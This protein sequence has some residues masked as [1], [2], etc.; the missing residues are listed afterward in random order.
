MSNT[1]KD[2]E[3]HVEDAGGKTQYFKSWP[4]ALELAAAVS[5]STGRAVNVDVV[6][7]SR[8]AARKWAGDAGVEVF[9][10]D[11]EASVHERLVVRVESQGR[12]A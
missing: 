1:H 3:F 11:P 9:E 6:A 8:E 2:L 10:E 7:W 5:A 4:K 12:I